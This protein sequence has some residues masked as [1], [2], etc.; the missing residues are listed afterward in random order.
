MN[1]IVAGKQEKQAGSLVWK[2]VLDIPIAVD[3]FQTLFS[4]GANAY[5]NSS[6]HCLRIDFVKGATAFVPISCLLTVDNISQQLFLYGTY[7]HIS[8]QY[9]IFIGFG[10]GQQ[11]SYA[12]LVIQHNDRNATLGGVWTPTNDL[13][14]LQIGHFEQINT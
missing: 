11:D 13:K 12:G 8:G 10:N 14:L 1:A 3:S 9:G 5:V 7:L 2:S 4:S 6:T